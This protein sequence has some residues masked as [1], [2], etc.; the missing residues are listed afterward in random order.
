MRSRMQIFIQ[1][2]VT[3]IVTG[4]LYALIALGYS[5]VY[6]ILKLLNFAHGDIFMVGAFIGYFAIRLVRRRDR[7]LDPGRAAARS[8][9]SSVAMLGGGAARRRDRALRLPAAAR[10]AADRAADH[11]ARRL[12][13]PRERGAARSSAAT[14]SATTTAGRR[15]SPSSVA[16]HIAGVHIALVQIIDRRR[17]RSC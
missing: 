16:I 17:Q 5:M 3:G 2:L 7:A 11:R 10:R 4:C 12:V 14:T 15:S 9:C 13:L 6:G 8:S 1:T